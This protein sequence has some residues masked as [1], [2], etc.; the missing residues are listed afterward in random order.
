MNISNRRTLQD[1]AAAR[2]SAQANERARDALDRA[3]VNIFLMAAT[4]AAAAFVIGAAI[5]GVS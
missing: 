4:F 1:Y 3:R 5:W 2:L